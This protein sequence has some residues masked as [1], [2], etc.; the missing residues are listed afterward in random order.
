ME[1]A[2]EIKMA[3]GG[4]QEYERTGR[5]PGG[6]RPAVLQGERAAREPYV[7]RQARGAMGS[8]A[9]AGVG[10]GGGSPAGPGQRAVGHSSARRW[11]AVTGRRPRTRDTLCRVHTPKG[12]ESDAMAPSFILN[13]I[14]R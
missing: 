1:K 2:W 13:K 9:A 10:R 8:P 12:R 6:T 5:S 4:T 7:R 14:F 3:S 11:L